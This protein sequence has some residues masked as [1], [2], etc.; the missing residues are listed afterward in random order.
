MAITHK[1]NDQLEK[2]MASFATVPSFEK[3][4]AIDSDGKI[5]RSEKAKSSDNV[6]SK[7]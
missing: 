6:K 2:M 5:L 1:K 3:P 4:L 7:H